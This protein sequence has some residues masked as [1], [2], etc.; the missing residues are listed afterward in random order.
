MVIKT[1]QN[2]FQENYNLALDWEYTSPCG[3]RGVGGWP[4]KELQGLHVY[5]LVYY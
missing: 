3:T 1:M 2:I 5:E 4:H